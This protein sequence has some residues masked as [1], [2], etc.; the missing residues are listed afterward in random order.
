[1]F[2]QTLKPTI[3]KSYV[4]P[5]TDFTAGKVALIGT[6]PEIG[7]DI[8]KLASSIGI[9]YFSGISSSNE[10][11]YSIYAYTGGS[12]IHFVTNVSQRLGF[13]IIWQEYI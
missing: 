7:M 1:M 12:R 8:D 4:V 2:E 6:A 9:A 5:V 10:F 3:T 11:L 13:R